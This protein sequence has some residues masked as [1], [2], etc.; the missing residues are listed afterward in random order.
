MKSPQRIKVTLTYE[1][2]IIPEHYP[3]RLTT[4][5]EMAKMDIPAA[6]ILAE[7]LTVTAEEIS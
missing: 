2:D 4:V 5:T 1:Y 7:N 6:I 3:Q